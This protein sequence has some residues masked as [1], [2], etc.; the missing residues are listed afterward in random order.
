MSDPWGFTLGQRTER[1]EES[2]PNTVYRA[3][4]QYVLLVSMKQCFSA[5]LCQNASDKSQVLHWNSCMLL[6]CEYLGGI[7]VGS[8]S[9]GAGRYWVPRQG[10]HIKTGTWRRLCC[11]SFLGYIFDVCS[12]MFS[13]NI[14][15]VGNC[16]SKHLL[17]LAM[18]IRSDSHTSYSIFLCFPFCFEHVSFWARVLMRLR[19]CKALRRAWCIFL[20]QY[21]FPGR[22]TGYQSIHVL[23]FQGEVNNYST[24]K[25]TRSRTVTPQIYQNYEGS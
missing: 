19:D 23:V 20:N 2:K 15:T 3:L 12:S 5:L 24:G 22:D 14:I 18:I 4:Q 21:H 6:V 9:L 13:I 11:H 25:G 10:T 7:K 16:D 1:R 8:A 17:V